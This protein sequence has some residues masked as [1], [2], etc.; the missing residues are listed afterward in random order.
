MALFRNG[1]FSL[2]LKTK[3][4]ALFAIIGLGISWPLIGIGAYHAWKGGFDHLQTFLWLQVPYDIGRVSGAL[5]SAAV[6]LLL[7]RFNIFKWLL[8]RCAAV[9]QMALTNYLLTSI[10]MRFIYVWSPLHWY[11]YVDYYKIYYAVAAM[12]VFNM[13]FS[14]VWLRF[15][16]FGPFEWCWRS[17]T[18]WKRQPMLL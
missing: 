18:Y 6:I 16:R 5:G 7:I 12:W 11:G 15:F 14:T 17:L 10:T 2:K 13:A 1:F 4:Y 3:T 8:A 9:G